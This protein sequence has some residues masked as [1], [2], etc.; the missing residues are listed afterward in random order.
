MKSMMS[1][2]SG[3]RGT[4]TTVAFVVILGYFVWNVA[5]QTGWLDNL[6]IFSSHAADNAYNSGTEYLEQEQYNQ[7]I[8]DFD[9]AIRLD[10][11]Y[12][13]VYSNRGLAYINLGQYERAILDYDEAIRLDPQYG[14]AYYNRGIAYENLGQQEQ[15]DLDFA[16]AKELGVE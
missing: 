15:A 7:A 9:E 2:V 10:P 6:G 8:V 3:R 14:N 12:A 11:Q 4:I 16:K 1:S 5:G 13:K